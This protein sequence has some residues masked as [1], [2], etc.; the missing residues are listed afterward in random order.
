MLYEAGH[1]PHRDAAAVV[2][3]HYRTCLLQLLLFSLQFISFLF[4]SYRD[5]LGVRLCI[6]ESKKIR[7][8]IT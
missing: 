7:D 6:C 3:D 5:S 1:F 8:T 4:L 2:Y